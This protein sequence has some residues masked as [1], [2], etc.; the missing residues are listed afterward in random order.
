MLGAEF[1]HRALLGGTLVGFACGYVGAWVGLRRMALTTEALSHAIFPGVA[2]AAACG[3][4]STLGLFFGG[5]ASALLVAGGADAVARSS[6]LKQDAA[7]GILYACSYAAGVTV[8]SA[9]GKLLVVERLLLGDLFAL[10]NVDLWQLWAVVVGIVPVLVLLERP[11]AIVLFNSDVARSMGIRAGAVNAFLTIS[12][13][14]ISVVSFKSSGV[15]PVVALLLAP[16]A[17]MRMLSDRLSSILWG[18]AILGSLGAFAGI[19]LS[20]ALNIVSGGVCIA[21]VL[22]FSFLLVYRFA[23]SRRM[24]NARGMG[25]PSREDVLSFR[26]SPLLQGNCA[27]SRM[28]PAVPPPLSPVGLTAAQAAALK[29]AR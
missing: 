15:V 23:P 27:Q 4:I 1:Q 25:V 16:G 21:L 17:T 24:H 28:L 22:G 29:E 19:C 11:L 3:C 9:S 20:C 18:G 26:Q 8:L 14:I 10:S 6:R 7:L 12:L 2:I 5:L 13:V